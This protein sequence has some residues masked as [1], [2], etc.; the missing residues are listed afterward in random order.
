MKDITIK[1]RGRGDWEEWKLGDSMFVCSVLN[2]FKSVR[3]H[4]VNKDSEGNKLIREL[5]DTIF[6]DNY[7][8]EMVNGVKGDLI[9]PDQFYLENNVPMIEYLNPTI[10]DNYKKYVTVQN[11]S[12]QGSRSLPPNA[13]NGITKNIEVVNLNNAKGNYTLKELFDTVYN[14]EF[15]L[16]NISGICTLAMSC[17]IPTQLYMKKEHRASA[18]KWD[19]ALEC[20]YRDKNVTIREFQ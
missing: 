5:S 19:Y 13:F 18:K 4:V 3:V 6:K 10:F 1:A 2:H 12:K 9:Y 8:F 17:R 11:W 16:G 15:H 14:A 7:E 20:V